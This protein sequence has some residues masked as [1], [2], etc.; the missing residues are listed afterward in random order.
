[1]EAILRNGYLRFSIQNLN[2][3]G[4]FYHTCGGSHVFGIQNKKE[5]IKTSNVEYMVCK[6][7]QE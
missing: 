4:S 6:D 2:G 7:I 3:F 5:R 1:M